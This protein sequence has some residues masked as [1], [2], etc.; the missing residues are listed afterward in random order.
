MSLKR[1]ACEDPAESS[2]NMEKMARVEAVNNGAAIEPTV[3][4][5]RQPL[6]PVNH[7]TRY[8]N[9]YR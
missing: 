4:S 3:S 7:A 1:N 2:E 6:T 5:P 9:R 8:A